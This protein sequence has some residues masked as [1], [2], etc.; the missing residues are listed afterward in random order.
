M[1]FLEKAYFTMKRNLILD[2]GCSGGKN[3]RLLRRKAFLTRK[4]HLFRMIRHSLY[5][6]QRMFR[7][8][9]IFFGKEG[10]SYYGQGGRHILRQADVM[11]QALFYKKKAF[12]VCTR[13][14]HPR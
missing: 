8:K 2:K 1:L 6:S 5:I 4:R 12:I 13:E 14:R 10:I 11:R 9:V 7:Q 3:K